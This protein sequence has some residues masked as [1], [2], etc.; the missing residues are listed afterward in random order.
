[1]RL[2]D[3]LSQTTIELVNRPDKPLKIYSCGPTVYD[4]PHLGNWYAFL[5]WELLIRSLHKLGF[6]TNWIMNITDVGHLTSDADEGEDKLVKKA[7]SQQQ[8]AY[9]IADYYTTYFLNSLQSLNFKLPDNLPKAT[10]HI[11]EQLALIKK[12]EALGLTYVI[13]DGVYY[14]TAQLADY[15]K[16][17]Q[18]V[19]GGF[20]AGARVAYNP[21]KRQKTDF[22]L[23]KFSPP[24]QVRDM[25]WDSPW[26]KGFPGWHLECSAM[27]YAYLGA[28]LD[29]H[30]GGIDHIPIHHTNEL[31][32]SEP[33]YGQPLAKIWLHSNFITVNGQKMSKSLG[34]FYTLEDLQQR[35]YE[36]WLLRL[37]VYHS[38]YA[39]ATDF[40]WALLDQAQA[41][42]RRWLALADRR[43]QLQANCQTP[44]PIA[45]IESTLAKIL[46]ALSDDLNSP[47]A[48]EHLDQL[49]KQLASRPLPVACQPALEA[50]CGHLDDIFGL[51]LSQRPDLT[52]EAR[53]LL[54]KRDQARR[55]A[56][57]PAADRLRQQLAT[58]GFEIRD[59]K[60]GQLWTGS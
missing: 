38:R 28:S 50:V 53:E 47:L 26:G 1:M 10:E 15:G 33:V 2:R 20:L 14:D 8:T 24:D 37:A 12:L 35:G 9:Q 31:A 19:R 3:T 46:A 11:K 42:Y 34:N 43:F 36:P 58:K 13:D 39:K 22:A 27:A 49:A 30:T 55:A 4:Y 16:L 48:L 59:T 54:A 25:E 32:Q 29:I 57:F 44:E 60:F 41:R 45:L 40:N 56:D 18:A 21:E 51:K 52:P 5:R 6:K 7:Q 23:W 17:S